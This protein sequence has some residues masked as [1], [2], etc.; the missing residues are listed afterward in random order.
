MSYV[1]EERFGGRR[2]ASAQMLPEKLQRGRISA[3][4][5]LW[6]IG[7]AAV[8][9]ECMTDTRVGIQYH[10]GNV[11]EGPMDRR[12]RRRG[13]R[14]SSAAMC[15]SRGAVRAFASSRTPS[16]PTP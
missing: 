16:M 6:H 15:N 8:A 13:H 12:L 10:A 14:A 9:G 4:G 3:L 11:F 5:R 1:L 2:I 7:C